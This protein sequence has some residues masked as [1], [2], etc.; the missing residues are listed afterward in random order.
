MFLSKVTLNNSSLAKQE[1]IKLL[2]KGA[3]ASHQLL[4]KLFADTAE[5]QRPFIF[6]EEINHGV[7]T[8]YVLSRVAPLNKPEIFVQHV[9]PFSPK[10][11]AG[12]RLAFQ[13]RANP[14][15]NINDG[16][17]NGKNHDVLM[18]AKT[19]LKK[20]GIQDVEQIKLGQEAAARDWLQDEKRLNSLGIELEAVP[21]IVSYQQHLSYKRQGK[22]RFSTVDYQGVLKVVQPDR[23]VTKIAEGIG[24]A[25]AFGCGLMLMRR[26]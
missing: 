17:K 3:Y 24:R 19:K 8:F 2:D 13:L 23:F 22:I 14:T 4:W 5:Q 15:I 26:V 18:H 10:L 20:S 16:S 25:K 11:V 9:K 7:P 1:L 12:S 21:D 6:R